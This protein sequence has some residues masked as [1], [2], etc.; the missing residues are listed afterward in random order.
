[1]TR[2]ALITLF[3]LILAAM[4]A[5]TTYASMGRSIFDLNPVVTSDRWFQATLVDAYCGFLTFYVWV[6]FR[7]KGSWRKLLWF[8]L[9]MS[10]GN[11]AMSV[12]VLLQLRSWQP[13][14]GFERLLLGPR[15][16][17]VS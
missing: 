11:I 4:L 5:V 10:L 15:A 9:I 17:R 14:L 7:E 3:A 16:T 6:A 12:Y 8:V 1:M 13:S 2:T